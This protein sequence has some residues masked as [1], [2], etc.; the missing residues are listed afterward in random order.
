MSKQK[1]TFPFVACSTTK[2]VAN[3]A[4]YFYY[5]AHSIKLKVYMGDQVTRNVS[6]NENSIFVLI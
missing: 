4:K 3:T 1:G 2:Y 6:Q 5:R